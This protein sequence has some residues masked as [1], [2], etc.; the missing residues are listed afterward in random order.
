MNDGTFNPAEAG[1]GTHLI[2]VDYLGILCSSSATF[3]VEV[4]PALEAEIVVSDTLICPGEGVELEA[5]YGGG[6]PDAVVDFFW[7]QDLIALL[8]PYHGT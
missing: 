4:L 1:A 7:N 6:G 3:E 5:L 2:T 8:Y